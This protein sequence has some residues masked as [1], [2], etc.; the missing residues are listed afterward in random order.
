MP[1]YEYTALDGA[2]K[3]RNGIVDADS[4]VAA[5][6]GAHS[7]GS[8]LVLQPTDPVLIVGTSPDRVRL[9]VDRVAPF[10]SVFRLLVLSVCAA[11][12]CLMLVPT[13]QRS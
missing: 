8:S 11:L 4:A 2:G 13:T 1:V 10:G 6:E 7:A 3:N 5:R 12:L 9:D